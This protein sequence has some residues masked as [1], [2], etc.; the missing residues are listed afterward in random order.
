M[1][2][3]SRTQRVIWSDN[4]TLRDI[5]AALS[6]YRA[7]TQTIGLVAADDKIYIA[8]E[9]PYNS[10]YFEV[11]S[12]NAAASTVSVEIWQGSDWQAARDVIDET[13]AS[14][15]S[16]AQSGLISFAMDI[17]NAGWHCE[18][19]SNAIPALTGTYIYN[20]YW[21]R[22]TWSGNWTGTTALKYIGQLFAAD[23]QV[24]TCY[25]DLANTDLMA[26]WETGKTSWREQAFAASDEIVR[27][28]RRR[29]V[30][31]RRDQIFDTSLLLDACVHKTAA[32]VY[33]GL[34]SAYAEAY[35][36]AVKRYDDAMS[37][38]HFE[39][40]MDANGEV[41]AAEKRYNLSYLTR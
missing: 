34:G 11:S 24:F 36:R 6:D 20:M 14:G 38:K 8:S 13:A 33:G 12:A 10:R 22:F 28:M 21:A 32:I 16:M 2:T 25:P 1:S 27:D 26:A 30:I 9:L 7:A 23:D 40:D 29:G 41:S 15:A 37:L 19:I 3:V 18:R 31:M 17:D 5:T 35:A 4:G 39:V